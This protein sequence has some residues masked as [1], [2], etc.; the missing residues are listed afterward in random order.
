MS[1]DINPWLLKCSH[2]ERPHTIFCTL[3]VKCKPSKI[4]PKCCHKIGHI[5]FQHKC[6]NKLV[7][8]KEPGQLVLCDST[9][10]CQENRFVWMSANLT[11]GYERIRKHIN[12]SNSTWYLDMFRTLIKWAGFYYNK[13]KYFAFLYCKSNFKSMRSWKSVIK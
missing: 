3:S 9:L 2:F 11:T 10:T 8:R 7:F 4:S 13:W 5:T 6:N 12:A 1:E